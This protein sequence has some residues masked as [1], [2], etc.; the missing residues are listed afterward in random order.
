MYDGKLLIG[1]VKALK[2]N[3]NEAQKFRN[4]AIVLDNNKASAINEEGFVTNDVVEDFCVEKSL[5]V[6]LKKIHV[7]DRKLDII[8]NQKDINE[9]T[10]IVKET[11]PPTYARCSLYYKSN[12]VQ[13]LLCWNYYLFF[14]TSCGPGPQGFVSGTYIYHFVHL[15]SFFIIIFIFI[16]FIILSFCC[17]RSKANK[18]IFSC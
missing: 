12:E 9:A 7:I 16:I 5:S 8:I 15:L 1:Q 6:I 11:T 3:K 10:A 17:K 14:I 2:N 18:L 13:Y 4:G